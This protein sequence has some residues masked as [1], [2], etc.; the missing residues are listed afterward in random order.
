MTS[1]SRAVAAKAQETGFSGVVRV[2][3]PG[4]AYAEAFGWADRRHQIANTTSTRFPIASATKGFTAVTVISLVESGELKLGTTARSVLGNDLPLIADD[5]TVDT[6]LA[7]RSGIGDYL[8][9]EDDYEV[10]DYVLTV[11]PHQLVDT[12]DYLAV[13]DG[14]ETVFPADAKFAY[15]NGGYVVLA[16]IAERASGVPFHELVRTRVTEPAGMTA[17]EF[18]RSDELP[19]DAAIG[20]LDEG[21]RTHVLHLPVLGSGD[22]G[23]Y[24]TADDLHA[25]WRALFAGR[26]V[27]PEGVE[28]LV[29]VRSDGFS[30]D[31]R[32]GRGFW[33]DGSSDVVW[34]T[35][36]DAGVACATSHDQEHGITHTVIS[37]ESDGAW[38]LF[39]L[40]DDLLLG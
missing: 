33:I 38:D 15:N 8:D 5:V 35:G 4:V 10:S 29:G 31:S 24:S 34:L 39:S 13:L 40:L 30:E 9:E 20:Y 17:T 22:G 32:Y 1:I 18:L 7:H 2:D 37:N 16:L 25:F 11:P 36:S 26:L 3:A 19:G 27:S 28:Q 14:F 21:M 12:E 23:S 6:L